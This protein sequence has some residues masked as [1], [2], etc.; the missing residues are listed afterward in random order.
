MGVRADD[1]ESSA[2]GEDVEDDD[3]DVWRDLFQE[4]EIGDVTDLEAELGVNA[5]DLSSEDDEVF[6]RSPKRRRKYSQEAKTQEPDNPQHDEMVEDVDEWSEVEN[7]PTTAAVVRYPPDPGEPTH[8]ERI[9]HTKT[10]L[11]PRS[12]CDICTMARGR[13]DAHSASKRLKR[14]QGPGM[15]KVGMDYK[16]LGRGKAQIIVM[17]DHHTKMTFA[18][19]VFSKGASDTWAM[20]RCEEDL[21]DLG[22]ADLMLKGDGEPALK[23]VQR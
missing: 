3:G 12:W 10:H 4:E 6:E 5:D 1:E 17:R 14:Q 16:S 8:K 13:E 21:E 2:V 9:D 20:N 22:Y 7:D 15:A 23:Q 11:P 19:P 18:H